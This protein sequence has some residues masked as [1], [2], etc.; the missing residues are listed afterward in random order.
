MLFRC[1]FFY[2]LTQGEP[3]SN[4]IHVPGLLQWVLSGSFEEFYSDRIGTV[5]DGI[6]LTRIETYT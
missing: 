5:E 2:S 6:T 4:S 3:E 1:I